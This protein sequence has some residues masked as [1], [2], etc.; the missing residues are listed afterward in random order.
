MKIPNHE[1]ATIAEAKIV[2]YLLCETHR[3]GRHKAIFFRRFGYELARWQRLRDDLL[4]LAHD[5]V[6]AVE[7]SP[8]GTKYIVEG[9]ITA[10]DGRTPRVR[11]VW[12]IEDG[13]DMP[14]F[15]TAYP[16]KE[17]Q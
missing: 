1:R 3:D 17:P 8:F 16:A 7:P 5:D 11:T 9:I 10:P 4:L 2:E 13:D 14:R 12:F 6:S 15:A